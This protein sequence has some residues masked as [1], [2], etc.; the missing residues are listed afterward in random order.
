MQTCDVAA[1]ITVT[2][3]GYN[4]TSINTAST[5]SIPVRY[6]LS[7]NNVISYAY[8]M[9]LD[10]TIDSICARIEGE[11]RKYYIYVNK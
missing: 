6:Y 4:I 3:S 9:T 8:C 1:I 2:K 5:V 7:T 10:I 11:V